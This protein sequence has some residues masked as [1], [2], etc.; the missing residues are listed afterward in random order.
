MHE[1]VDCFLTPLC[2]AETRRWLAILARKQRA[3]AFHPAKESSH[4]SEGQIK[5]NIITHFSSPTASPPSAASWVV[6]HDALAGP[7]T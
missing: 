3:S 4:A 7:G 5:S 1:R 2:G 6:V